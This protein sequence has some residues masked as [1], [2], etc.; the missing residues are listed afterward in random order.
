MQCVMIVL[1]SLTIIVVLTML[2]A[3]YTG[4]QIAT[5][6]QDMTSY[7]NRM[8]QA[9]TLAKK[10]KIVDELSYD[11]RF[12]DINKQ[13]S[14]MRVA[15]EQL[16]SRVQKCNQ[17]APTV[18]EGIIVEKGQELK[19]IST[20]NESYD[21]IEELKKVFFEFLKRWVENDGSQQ[22]VN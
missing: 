5:P 13:Y 19:M 21:E 11:N 7:T 1:F 17:L 10:I 3:W 9:S 8:K 20:W 2:V 18:S 12:K 15:K 14:E 16:R 4:W 6:V 22:N